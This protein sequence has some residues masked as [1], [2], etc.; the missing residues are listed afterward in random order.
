ML[1]STSARIASSASLGGSCSARG[2]SPRTPAADIGS[3]PHLSRAAG[4]PHPGGQ[5]RCSSSPSVLASRS[6]P[7]ACRS[8]SSVVGRAPVRRARAR[9]CRDPARQRLHAAPPLRAARAADR[10]DGAGRPRRAR[11]RA[12]APRGRLGGGARLTHAFNRMLD[13]LEVERRE[14]RAAV[15]ARRSRSASALAQDL[16]D[17][18][19][20]ALTGDPAAPR[21]TIQDAPAELRRELRETS[22]SPRR[23][24]RSCC[25]SRAS[26]GP[27]CST[28]TG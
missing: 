22:G 19:N 23:R 1:R 21:G 20:Q 10:D 26:C 14:A 17:E 28:T 11:R 4:Q 15:L 9:A 6:R 5:R 7:H 3:G 8:I 16:H 2:V 13:R 24:W 12:D 27:P 25:A 18:V